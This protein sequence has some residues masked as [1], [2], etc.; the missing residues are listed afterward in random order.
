MKKSFLSLAVIAIALLIGLNACDKGG[1][2]PWDSRDPMVV[3]VLPDEDM[4]YF[5]ANEFTVEG[6]LDA[7]D[8]EVYPEFNGR[9]GRDDHR[10]HGDRDKWRKKIKRRH[11]QGFELRVLLRKLNLTDRQKAKFHDIMSSYRDCVKDIM[12]NTAEQRKEIMERARAVRHDIIAKFRAGEIDRK[13]A[14]SQLRELY[15][16]VR[17]AMNELVD[18]EAL[19]NCYKRML[20]NLYQIL[21]PE[22]KRIF[23]QWLKN[24]KNPC[25]EGWR[26]DD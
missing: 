13:E 11:G 24:S 17:K 26:F 7:A 14:I 16:K 18:K 15:V 1:D 19:C 12:M 10:D 21:T 2:N 4:P 3:Q 22:Q 23:L 5:D 20:H 6:E 25:L 8:I 9:D